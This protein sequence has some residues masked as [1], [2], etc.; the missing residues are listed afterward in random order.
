MAP[1][2]APNCRAGG[3]EGCAVQTATCACWGARALV[4]TLPAEAPPASEPTCYP[5]PGSGGRRSSWCC[6]SERSRWARMSCCGLPPPRPLLWNCPAP[7]QWGWTRH[8]RQAG[9]PFAGRAAAGCLRARGSVPKYPKTP[10]NVV[11]DED[12]G[13]GEGSASRRGGEGRDRGRPATWAP[14]STPRTPPIPRSAT[15]HSLNWAQDIE[16]R[17]REAGRHSPLWQQAPAAH[18]RRVWALQ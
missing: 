1:D 5:S 11:Q 14:Q 9:V 7:W 16:C 15:A 12:G 10:E 2:G 13:D 8:C 18:R 17:G 3:A 6:R 4:L